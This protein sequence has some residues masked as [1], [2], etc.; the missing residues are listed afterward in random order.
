MQTHFTIAQKSSRVV[1]EAEAEIRKCVH[2]GFCMAT[3]PTYQLLG[4]ERDGPRGRIYMIKDMLENERAPSAAVVTHIDRCLSCLACVTTC[5]SD[6]DYRRLV[7]TARDYIEAKYQR[8]WFE[9]MLRAVLAA[10]LPY[11]GRMRAAL[12]LASLTGWAAP[13]M[14]ARVQAMFALAKKRGGPAAKI[15]VTK[16]E[17]KG[18]IAMLGGC[19]EPVM[20]PAVQAA[21]ERLLTRAGYEIVRAPGE[22]CCGALTHHLGKDALGF[23]RANVD[24]WTREIE[25]AGLTAIVV[26]ASG[27]GSVVKD[28]GHMLAGDPAYAAKAA[29]VA[30]L[31][32]DISEVLEAADL[33]V[34]PPRGVKVAYQSA[35]SLQHGQK[36]TT[37]PARLLAAAGYEVVTPAEAHLCCGSAGTYNVLQPVIAG[38]LRDRKVA[39]L[40]A[41]GATVVASGNI[42]CITQLAGEAGLAVVHTVELLDWAYGGPRP[43]GI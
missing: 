5:P 3:C 18:R 42:G 6:V 32:K 8:P 33:P 2:C 37:G 7:D 19:A 10:V 27:C 24:A 23:A 12:G 41:T 36:I 14:P 25:G 22:G 1:A 15:P 30:A 21:A 29:K 40:V 20:R 26:T 11:P 35:C 39:A 31:A 9:R 17:P 43:E 28:Y 16:C 34:L 4:D 13:W 38:Q